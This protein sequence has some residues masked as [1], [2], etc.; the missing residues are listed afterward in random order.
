MITA[1]PLQELQIELKATLQYLWLAITS[2]EAITSKDI[3]ELLLDLKNS[4]VFDG[5][6]NLSPAEWDERQLAYFS[7]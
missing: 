6:T 5:D 3:D 4:S 2:G 1:D 7:I